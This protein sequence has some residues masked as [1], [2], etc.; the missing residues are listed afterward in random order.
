[1]STVYILGAGASKAVMDTSPLNDD[2]L[3]RAIRA[4]DA[5]PG[6]ILTDDNTVKNIQSFI[7]DFYRI[8]PETDLL[9]PIEHVL[10]QID[11]CIKEKHALG[12]YSL[13]KLK[14]LKDDLIYAICRL[15]AWALKEGSTQLMRDFVSHLRADDTIISLNYDLIVDNSMIRMGKVPFYG[16]KVRSYWDYYRGYWSDMSDDF[17]SAYRDDFRRWTLLKPHGSLNWLYCP[18]CDAIDITPGLKGV[19]YIFQRENMIEDE[20]V[21]CRKCHNTRYQ[22][23]IVT[24][25]AVREYGDRY[26]TEIWELAE[27]QLKRASKIVFIGYSF[28]G[29]DQILQTKIS[30]AI[31]ENRYIRT[32]ANDYSSAALPITVVD[33]VKNYDEADQLKNATRRRYEGVFGHVDYRPDGFGKYVLSMM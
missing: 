31:Y 2:L 28:P 6:L 32:Q 3:P 9:P 11:L 4:K 26:L 21:M 7:R 15:L 17:S 20:L 29:A 19:T 12:H 23:Y 24:P 30:R 16:F 13:E 5:P 8:N 14:D 25:T 22:P 1:M 18:Q 10:T 33:Y 27:E